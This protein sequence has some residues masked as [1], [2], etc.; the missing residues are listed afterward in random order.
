MVDD[1]G[2]S[3]TISVTVVE[4]TVVVLMECGLVGRSRGTSAGAADEE[5]A[6]GAE[7]VLMNR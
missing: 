3:V 7:V 1:G 4:G 6:A 5:G 2:A